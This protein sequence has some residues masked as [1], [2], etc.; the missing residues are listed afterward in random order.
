MSFCVKITSNVF[1]Q[2][3][4]KIKCLIN[5][6]GHLPKGKEKK[7]IYSSEVERMCVVKKG[8]NHGPAPIPEEGKWVKSKEVTDTSATPWAWFPAEQAI[9]PLCFSSSESIAIL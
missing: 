4:K 7:M 6:R 3:K 2:K 1:F 8:A 5:R 9:T